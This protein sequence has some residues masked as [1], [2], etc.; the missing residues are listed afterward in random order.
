[1]ALTA[2]QKRNQTYKP[3]RYI[4]KP[5]VGDIVELASISTRDVWHMHRHKLLWQRFLVQD[6]EKANRDENY[7]YNGWYK[8]KLR[9]LEPS[10]QMINARAGVNNNLRMNS[11]S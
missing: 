10:N 9:M 3:G 5:S 7:D 11:S 4:G 2:E 1:M 8:L 6:V